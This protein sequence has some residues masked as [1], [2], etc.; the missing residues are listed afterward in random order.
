MKLI[1]KIV[2]ICIVA[3][4]LMISALTNVYAEEDIAYGIEYTDT[5]AKVTF[6]IT[7]INAFD[8]AIAYDPGKLTVKDVGYTTEFKELQS[9]GENMTISVY[10][11]DAKDDN[12][13]TYVVFTGAGANNATGKA[14]AFEGKPL[15]TVTF[16]G[17]L[18]S[19]VITLVTD[20]AVVEDIY[21]A[22]KIAEISLN[23]P[24]GTT[25]TPVPAENATSS[26]SADSTHSDNNTVVADQSDNS[27][28]AEGSE[29]TA[30]VASESETPKD[31]GNSTEVPEANSD[32]ES[33]KIGNKDKEAANKNSNTWIFVGIGI[34]VLLIV[35][36]AAVIIVLKKKKAKAE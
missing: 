5:T 30:P 8:L 11:E 10:N 7:E 14:I 22:E 6:Y 19:S 33:E 25:I 24:A 21:T 16:E 20:S 32:N 9:G 15:A 35:A 1:K 34:V 28:S 12:G 23:Q 26:N 4:I 2:M 36:V 3:S 29:T 17:D 18:S 31:D 13:N 27:T